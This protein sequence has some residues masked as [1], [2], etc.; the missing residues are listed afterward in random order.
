MKKIFGVAI[1]SAT[2]FLTNSVF[3]NSCWKT[4]G[5]EGE[6][7]GKAK[8][9]VELDEAAGTG[10]IKKLLTDPTAKCTACK[11]SKKNK[12]IQGMQIISGMK[13]GDKA[14]SILD[15]KS[16]KTYKLKIWKEGGNLKVRGYLGFF[17]RTQTWLPCR[18]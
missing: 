3:A 15:P 13:M 4:I 12:P 14:G 16:G 18:R 8:S 6:D 10:T 2:F 9:Y 5:D 17:Y 7:K 11:G 1:L